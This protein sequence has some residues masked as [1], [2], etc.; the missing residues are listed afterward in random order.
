MPH[1]YKAKLAADEALTVLGEERKAKDK[2]F[3]Y[4]ILRPGGLTDEKETGKVTLGKTGARGMV[5]RGDVA[6]V[7]ARL[8]AAEGANGWFDLLGGEEDTAEAVERVVKEGVNTIEGED[9]AVMKA[10]LA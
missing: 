8:L 1:Y 3:H 2:S 6:D 9:I 10:N 7:A 5:S 4:I